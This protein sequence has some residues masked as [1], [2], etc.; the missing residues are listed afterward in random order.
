M[1]IKNIIKI[2]SKSVHCT[3]QGRAHG[4][5]IRVSYPIPIGF[6]LMI[7]YLHKKKRICV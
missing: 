1:E 2:E 4:E 5:G 6:L 3:D 7:Y